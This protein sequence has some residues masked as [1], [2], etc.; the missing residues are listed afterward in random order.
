MTIWREPAD[1][2]V[3]EDLQAVV[4]GHPLVA[5]TILQ[6]AVSDPRE[7]LAFL[8]PAEYQPAS[9]FDLPGMELAIQRLLLAVENGEHVLVWGDF[10]VD[11]QTATSILASALSALG[12]KVSWHIPVRAR[13]S[14]GVNIPVLR[15]LL[16][17]G[18]RILLT[19]DTGISSHDALAYA[20]GQ[21]MDVIVTDHHQLPQ[22]LPDVLALVNPQM[23]P[24]EHPLASLPGV[25]V[26][27]K[28]VEGLFG[29]AGT[30][31]DCTRYLDLVALGIIADLAIMRGE[32]RYLAQRGLQV[33]R[34]TPR[35]GIQVMLD[36]AEVQQIYLTEEHVGFEIAP[37][38][39]ALGR[40][41]DANPAVEL[42]TT[43]DRSL[44]YSL[45]YVLESANNQRKLL[46]SQV[47]QAALAL[48]E[49]DR[50]VLDEPVL[51]L[52][53]PAW[54][55]GVLGIV[56]NQLVERF[57]KPAALIAIP[58]GEVGRGSARSTVGIDITRAISENADLLLNF[59]GHPMAAG[60][61]IQAENI[62]RF[63]KKLAFSVARQGAPAEPVLQID[64]Y[65][66]LTDL[67]LDL[68]TD[69]ERL[70]PFGPGNPGLVLASQRL[71]LLNQQTIGRSQEHLLLTVEDEQGAASKVI[72]WQ[73]A[74]WP[75]PADL[76]DL[77][78]RVRASTFRGQRDIQVEWVDY[79]LCEPEQAVVIKPE[80]RVIDLRGEAQ[81]LNSLKKLLAEQEG[82]DNSQFQV[83]A[84]G[85]ALRQLAAHK[86]AASSRFNLHSAKTLLVWT[87]PPE[88]AVWNDL[89]AVVQPMVVILFCQPQE[90]PQAEAFLN[91]LAGFVKFSLKSNAGRLNYQELAAAA[92]QRQMAVRIGVDWL[93]AQGL[94]RI[95]HG[96]LGDTIFSDAG[97]VDAPL[98]RGLLKDLQHVLDETR[99]YRGYFEK[100][101]AEVLLRSE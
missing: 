54:P 42:L 82:E 72:W 59:G 28:L 38:L 15:E 20:A 70:A 9:A 77:A 18:P 97:D 48:I 33:M 84:E 16:D 69:L 83:Y 71:R 50:A 87:A 36:L 29:E 37:R 11:G 76:F 44:A 64:S 85:E 5:R 66:P 47:L 51:V 6:R 95:Q 91:Q 30:G 39:N 98:A 79:R 7:A 31:L 92:G 46:T 74:G 52:A 101:S 14:H 49:Q 32:S 21:G 73:G 55:A 3:P 2:F 24:S 22:S 96:E 4:G 58:Q 81:A 94:V 34:T 80:R 35:L 10:D 25:G 67:T 86:I 41:G 90:M 89:L 93:A 19:C 100:A 75:A 43:A 13:E 78:Y 88:T 12:G 68:V 23:L 60:F 45:A 56:A 99:A 62:A 8:D 65:L 27:Y 1:L 53:H 40:I 61:A 17:G 63:R 57:H 26:A